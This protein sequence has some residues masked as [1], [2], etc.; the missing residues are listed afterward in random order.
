MSDN[1]TSRLADNVLQFCR[2]LRAAGVPVGPAQVLDALRAVACVGV[3]RRDDVRSALRAVLIGDPAHFRLFEQTFHIYFH[4]P[5]LL[6]RLTGVLS[7]ANELPA[8]RAQA[9]M[10]RVAEVL[11]AMHADVSAEESAS[12]ERQ[13]ASYSARESLR[14]K[15][16]EEMSVAEQL[17]AKALL[18]AD[19]EPLCNLRTRRFRLDARGDRLDLRRSMRLMIRN[20]GQLLKLARRRRRLRPPV[21]V[22]L[23]D[24]SGSMS[25]YSRM[26]L[27]FAHAMTSRA[28]AVHSFVFGTRLT[29]ITR[30]LKN[31]D[32]DA[33]LALVAKDVQDWDGGTRIAECLKSFNVGWGR[34]VL[35][36]NA[37]VILL[38]DGLER[39]TDADLE[40]Q[41]Q[42]LRGTCRRLVWLNP[43]LRYR[44]FAPKAFGIRAMLPNV[45]LFLPAHNVDSIAA[46]GRALRQGRKIPAHPRMSK[47]AA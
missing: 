30:H 28:A 14:S 8:D 15:D 22:F 21:L 43:M 17:E 41:M 7:A 16:F 27:H 1:E 11:R 2:T 44:D 42:R 18:R 23:C 31:R 9:A 35:A 24:I 4:N 12:D 10:R 39:D 6:E 47:V 32:A 26:F 25:R 3:V 38:S 5:Q 45:D 34:R 19:I 40:F 13:R 29:N 33:A 37:T 36:Q 46:L 20:D